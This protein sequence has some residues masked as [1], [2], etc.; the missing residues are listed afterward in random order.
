MMPR[1]HGA[2]DGAR[3]LAG[4]LRP[5]DSAEPFH[6][7][8]TVHAVPERPFLLQVVTVFGGLLVGPFFGHLMGVWLTPDSVVVQ[9]VGWFT[10]ALV[11]VGGT[12]LWIG[13]G[14]VTVV[15]SGLWR[16]LRGQRPGPEGFSPS[17]RVVPAGY[18]SYAILGVVGG[19]LVGLLAGLVTELAVATGLVAWTLFGL[20]Y[21]GSLSV[22]AHHGWLPFPEPE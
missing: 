9:T 22:A 14:I 10:F 5:V 11:Y 15:V 6:Q 2:L 20:A 21:G 3:V 8:P 18:R 17:H 4:W 7:E 13:I 12:M 19:V 1:R 16:L